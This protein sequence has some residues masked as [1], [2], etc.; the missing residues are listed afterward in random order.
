MSIPVFKQV[1]GS[2]LPMRPRG[3]MLKGW[4]PGTIVNFVNS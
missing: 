2:T 4:L 3:G 1:V